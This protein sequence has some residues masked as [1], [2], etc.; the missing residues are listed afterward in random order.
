MHAFEQYFGLVIL[1]GYGMTETASTITFNVNASDRRVNSAGKPVWGTQTQVWSESG[2]A[3]P[4]GPDNVG[5]VVTRGLHVMTGYLND[6]QATA[7]AFTGGWLRTGD[8]GYFDEDG[9]LFIVGRRQELIIRGGYNVY[10]REIEDVL[11]AHPAI[12][13]AAVVGFPH[14]RLGEDIL[15][16]IVLRA[17]A[18]LAPDELT[19]YLRDRLAAYKCPRLIEFRDELPRTNLGQVSKDQLIPQ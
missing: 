2:H 12:A 18:Q 8:L 19:G 10:P 6:P 17:G 15:A 5:E 7:A 4:P 16:V 3:L 14:D 13:E 9:F 1:E 11:L